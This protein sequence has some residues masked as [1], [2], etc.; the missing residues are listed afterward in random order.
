MATAFEVDFGRKIHLDM[1]RA[2]AERLLQYIETHAFSRAYG[3][4][5]VALREVLKKKQKQP[6]FKVGDV[7]KIIRS[8]N[9]PYSIPLGSLVV[10]AAVPP[11]NHELYHIG[12]DRGDKLHAA[13][14][15]LEF[16]R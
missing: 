8:N 5:T 1:T 10:V 7:C 15:Q 11:N 9:K 3:P 2:E 16:V 12:W 14:D 6:K 13:E 4:V